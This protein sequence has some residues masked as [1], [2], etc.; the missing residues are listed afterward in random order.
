LEGYAALKDII[1]VF[2]VDATTIAELNPSIRLPVFNG[3][4]HLPPG[5]RL[6]LPETINSDQKKIQLSPSKNITIK[7]KN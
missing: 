7:N 5:Y 6:H 4:R 2:K 3:L 1:T